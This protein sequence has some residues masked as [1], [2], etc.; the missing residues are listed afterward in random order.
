MTT[1]V[2]SLGCSICFETDF[3]TA[4]IDQLVSCPYCPLQ[5]CQVCFQR[6][7][8]EL[9]TPEIK[10][11]LCRQEYNLYQVR[12]QV[13]ST[14]FHESFSEHY[15]QI[16]L[17]YHQNRARIYQSSRL[18][19]LYQQKALLKLTIRDFE[20]KGQAEITQ[21]RRTENAKLALISIKREKVVA[22]RE[23]LTLSDPQEVEECRRRIREI[24]SKIVQATKTL[25]ELEKQ[26]EQEILATYNHEFDVL[27]YQK[28]RLNREISRWEDNPDLNSSE[29]GQNGPQDLEDYYY[30]PRIKCNGLVSTKEG[31][32]DKCQSLT[33][34][35]C[36]DLVETDSKAEHNCNPDLLKNLEFIQSDQSTKLCPRCRIPIQ[37]YQG[38]SDFFCTQCYLKFNFRTG[39][40][41]RGPFHNPEYEQYLAQLENDQ[42]PNNQCLVVL[43]KLRRYTD[44]ANVRGMVTEATRSALLYLETFV[45]DIT[46]A[47][48]KLLDMFNLT[49]HIKNYYAYHSNRITESRY[50]ED[51]LHRIK[52]ENRNLQL[53]DYLNT[54]LAI[55]E[56]Y[57]FKVVDLLVSQ[58][59]P[60]TLNLEAE[61]HPLA[62]YEE[63]ILSYF[64]DFCQQIRELNHRLYSLGRIGICS[65][66][67]SLRPRILFHRETNWSLRGVFYRD[68]LVPKLEI[69][70]D[71]ESSINY[72]CALIQHLMKVG[73]YLFGDLIPRLVNTNDFY[74]LCNPQILEFLKNL[75]DPVIATY[76]EIVLETGISQATFVNFIRERIKRL[77]ETPDSRYKEQL[78]QFLA[79]LCQNGRVSPLDNHYIEYQQI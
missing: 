63:E 46:R 43:D 29:S 39:K 58:G 28:H 48:N 16:L 52:G 4:E 62:Q 19:Q 64:K 22:E 68:Q 10:V 65:L 59:V 23:L 51:L 40:E 5:F 45:P 54:A 41:I 34:L 36:H 17:A 67:I 38:C 35:K 55:G 69:P 75:L 42:D 47:R 8:M 15:K 6:I 74:S 30:C 32:C 73:G 1:S 20:L 11:C 44:I 13:S 50:A 61:N 60:T 70:F 66:L 33:C 3:K 14:W 2:Q 72:K 49:Y 24:D 71:S 9:K 77:G 26:I 12:D 27:S 31:T 79:E 25:K 78:D 57:S 53:I 21:D 7:L 56:H 18:F 76:A 37:K